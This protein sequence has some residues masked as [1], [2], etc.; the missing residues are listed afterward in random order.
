MSEKETQ[1][2]I[3]LIREAK[4][5][6]ELNRLPKPGEPSDYQVFKMLEDQWSDGDGAYRWLINEG[7]SRGIIK[8]TKHP[9]Y[10]V[11]KDSYY[12]F[13]RRPEET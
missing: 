10:P 12:T 7:L 13:I 9:D 3:E 5:D 11:V 1:I 6:G 8:E 4:G 2:A